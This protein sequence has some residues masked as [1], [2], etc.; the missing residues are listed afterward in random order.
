MSLG[1]KINSWFGDYEEGSQEQNS[2]N[3]RPADELP[4]GQRSRVMSLRNGKNGE[5]VEKKIMLFEPSIFSDVKAIAARL[6]SGEAAVVNF[7][8]MDNQQA[9]RV[10]DFLSG[11]TFAIDGEISRVGEAIFLCT[12]HEFTV[13]GDITENV[14]QTD[15]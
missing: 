14:R 6:L 7:Q 13:E 4:R 2:Q 10:V 9:H 3:Q 1:D 8:K 12:P 15:F 11:V 5:V